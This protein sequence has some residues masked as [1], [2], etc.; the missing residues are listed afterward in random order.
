MFPQ[1]K[2]ITLEQAIEKRQ[3]IKKLVFTNGTFDLLHAGHV[4]YL[5]QARALG[6]ALFLGL[7]SDQSITRLKGPKRPLVIEE[8]RVH[9]LSGLS[10]VDAVIVFD[11]TTADQLI[12]GLQPN[13]YAKGGDYTLDPK[14]PGTYLPETP[15][16]KHYGG[17]IA[18]IPLQ[19]GRSTTSLIERILER[20]CEQA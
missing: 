20:Y 18:L 14:E 8:D 19:T 12:Q 16:V 1:S 7:N 15:T 17:E 2:Q 13:V 6:D 11:D 3:G 10:C 4:A 5:Q 9:I